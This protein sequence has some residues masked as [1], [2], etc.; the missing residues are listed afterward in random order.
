MGDRQPYTKR[1]RPYTINM[2]PNQWQQGTQSHRNQIR[3]LYTKLDLTPSS[4]WVYHNHMIRNCIPNSEW[5]YN[6][7]MIHVITY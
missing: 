6:N 1:T 5:I 2:L 3:Q 4:G 7:H